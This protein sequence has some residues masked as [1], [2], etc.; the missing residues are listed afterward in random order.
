MVTDRRVEG[1]RL[2]DWRVRPAQRLLESRDSA[3]ELSPEQLELLLALVEYHGEAVDRHSL[4]QRVW[5]DRVAA[6]H[7][8][9]A[10]VRSLREALGDDIHRPSYISSVP[11]RG[12]ALIAEYEENEDP[13]VPTHAEPQ[14]T[15]SSPFVRRLEHF[16]IELKRR[17]VFRVAGA[18]L[19]GMW[20]VLQVAEVTFEPL[21]LPD[22][23]MTALTILAVLGLPIVLV[24]AW[25]YEITPG[26]IVLDDGGPGGLRL[27]RARRRALAPIILVGVTLMAGVT[28]Y[29]WWHA[30]GRQP[31]APSTPGKVEPSAYSIAVLPLVDMSPAGEAAYLGD[32]LSEELSSDLAKLPGLRVAARTSSFAFRGKEVDVRSIG[33]Q[34]GVRYVL[35]GSVRRE[36]ER[37]RI[38]AQLIDAVTGFH[39]W[40]DSYDRS[41]QDLLAIQQDIS[42]A[43]AEQ[44]RIVLTP[45]QAVQLKAAPTSDP[46]AYDFYLA[47]LAELR[48]GGAMSRYDEAASLFERA[49]AIDP[50][51]ARAQAGLCEVGIMRYVRS[52]DPAAMHAAEASCRAALE[53]EAPLPETEAALAKLY[54]VGG[55]Y[56]QAEAVYRS[57]LRRAPRDAEF[58]I[59]LGGALAAQHREQEAEKEFREAIVV[60]PGYW[61]AYNSLGSFLFERGRA[62]EAVEAYR[63]VTEL[64]PGNTSGLSNLGA[65]LLT[66]GDLG[67][68]EK[69]FERSMA[70]EPGS[71]AV[72]NLGTVYY[73]TGRME[74]A[75]KMYTKAIEL[76]PKDETMWGARGDALWNIPSRRREAVEDYRRAVA[77]A[78][79]SLAINDSQAETWALLG[80][81]YARLD[82]AERSERYKNRALELGA[83][84][85]TVTYFAGLTAAQQGRKQEAS[86]L[87]RRAL[88]QGYP[89]LLVEREPALEGIP[90]D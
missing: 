9:R 43:I 88:E 57:L 2:G 30:I 17:H 39:V 38:T 55:R 52:K 7:E 68:A 36:G 45:E 31:V 40:T 51:F 90:I 24:V 10:V 53:S 15:A 34:L 89:R 44:L 21:R 64:A 84:L 77:L 70:I 18:Y 20:V 80:F 6:D 65:A 16:I 78:E 49:L 75:A 5:P 66:T 61:Q 12:Y 56:E 1:F 23:W 3:R 14:P 81:F 35:E 85:P 62:A 76:A 60:E 47:G 71:S 79:Q 33:E 8:L 67:Q 58:H 4:K 83:Q 37:V 69:A 22:W 13:S 87:V 26:G 86:Q 74:E 72:V 46:R 54:A 42:S 63:R 32:G 59:G 29:A 41:W 27:P 19:I 82:D 28:G 25:A 48:K 73:Y 50:G 11:R